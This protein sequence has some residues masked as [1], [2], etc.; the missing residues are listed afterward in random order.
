LQEQLYKEHYTTV[1]AYLLSLCGDSF[2][3]EDI[4][5][6]TFLRAFAQPD[7]ALAIFGARDPRLPELAHRLAEH[8]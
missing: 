7:T 8:L 6:E 1:Y 2:L 4:A 5:S 3:A